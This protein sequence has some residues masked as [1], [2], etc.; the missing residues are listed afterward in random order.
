VLNWLS[1]YAFVVAEL[2]FDQDGKLVESVLDVG[3]GPHG[4]A[5]A[6]P[7][8][9]FVGVD[10]SFP[11]AVAPGMIA[12]RNAPGPLPFEDASF[13]TVICLDVL[14]H[15][16]PAQRREFV[17]EL[18]R[19]AARRV[20]IACPS[21]EAAWIDDSVRTL[22]RSRGLPE[23]G[24]LSEHDE[25]GLPTYA[26]IREACESA[27]GFAA[28]ELQM[29][30]GLLSTMAVWADMFPE[31]GGQAV[32]ES[33][34]HARQW[35]DVFT[36]GRFGT[37]YRKGFA[38]ERVP[39]RRPRLL[40]SDLRE[41]LWSTTRCPA[42]GAS[43]LL[44][45]D[46]GALCR[47]CAHAVTREATGAF[48]MSA[49]STDTQRLTTPVNS[50]RSQ[51]LL[52]TPEW[53]DL[54]S[55]VPVLW[56]YVAGTSPDTDCA[57]CIDGVANDLGIHTIQELVAAVCER[58]ADG[59]PFGDVLLLDTPYE[60]EGLSVVTGVD[61]LV[62]RLGLEPVARPVGVEAVVGHARAIKQT[63]DSLAATIERR[64]YELAPDPWIS[65]TPLVTVRIA[66]WKGHEPLVR[67]TIPSVL[68]GTY[69]NVEV[70]VCSDGPDPVARA[71]VEAVEDPRVRYTELP[72]R[73]VYP[74]Q[75]WSFWETAGIYAMNEAV[76]QA[77]GTFIAPLDHD[78]AFTKDHVETLLRAAAENRADFIYGQALMED[79]DGGW[80]T[81]GSEPLQ[82]GHV[83]HGAIMFSSR[84]KHVRLDPDCW[85]RNEPGDWNM[86]RRATETGAPVAFAPHVVL[87]HFKER[88]SLAEH[89][90][91]ESTIRFANRQPNEIAADLERTGLDW[92]LDLPL[93]R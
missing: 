54:R 14:E 86:C 39:A 35:L 77:R 76:A 13:E 93:T 3:C 12:L 62:H 9:E 37:C 65:R 72:E 50:G 83:T 71:A 36:V 51:R 68:S 74:A 43:G 33:R 19:V 70:V 8:A 90:D 17:H 31:T 46:W 16:P 32:T 64:V 45:R 48:D 26:E 47:E 2:G 29:T 79:P 80:R 28:R 38:I 81:V 60:R 23:P 10:L 34:E 89:G 88:G 57:L 63:L 75:P 40:V 84:L 30:N 82:F 49:T 59:R 66:T 6:V 85:L 61:D 67:R 56:R 1:R 24:W 7:G 4:L 41:R 44:A 58:A 18:T 5:C 69:Q 42:C 78:D 22:Y 20:L 25:H 11:D 15:I 27:A 92:L 53:S 87:A 55:W 73:P 21:S 91:S 52:L